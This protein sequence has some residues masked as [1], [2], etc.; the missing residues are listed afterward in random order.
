MTLTRRGPIKRLLLAHEFALLLLITITGALGATWAY[1]WQHTSVELVR[2]NDLAYTTQRL[3][4]ELFRQIKDVTRAR[5]MEDPEALELYKDYSRRMEDHFN[6]LRGNSVAQDEEYAIQALQLSYRV[7]QQDMN[8]IF[9]DPYG[10]AAGA[11][12]GLLMPEQEQQMVGA[13]EA[14]AEGFEGVLKQSDAGI[15]GARGFWTRMVPLVIAQPIVLALA[16]MLFSRHRVQRGF[17]LPANEVIEGARVMRAGQLDHRIPVHG[18]D[19]VA[20]LS[21]ALNEMAAELAKSRDALVEKQ[22]QAALGALVPVVA[23]NIRNPLASIRASAQLLDH[24]ESAKDIEETKLAVIETVDRLG[25]W[26]NSLVSYLHPLQPQLAQQDLHRVT[27]ATLQLL[28]PRLSQKDIAMQK[29]GWDE[30]CVAPMDADLMEQALYGLLS[31]AID[32]SPVGET[33]TVG[34]QRRGSL[35][36]LWIEDRGPGMAWQPEPSELSPGPSTKRF[37]TG[38]GIPVAFKICTAHG[39]SLRFN[40]L[41]QGGTRVTVEVPLTTVRTD[42]EPGS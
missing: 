21:E 42:N 20:S 39:W 32:A 34:T 25:R 3:R 12:M 31:N 4:S 33:L 8:K 2:L 17:V 35:L 1:F 9:N 23:H 16:V 24:A 7:I 11:R 13:F 41:D 27:D 6:E 14:A 10:I 38:L 40:K 30:A 37:G 15:R 28:A 18:V 26:V 29:L 36:T 22:K 5:L 19:E